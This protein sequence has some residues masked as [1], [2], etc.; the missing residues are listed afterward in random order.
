M[1]SP[2]FSTDWHFDFSKTKK[3][4]FS[5]EPGV[6][7]GFSWV[8]FIL[9]NRSTG[10]YERVNSYW[11]NAH[12]GIRKVEYDDPIECYMYYPDLDTRVDA[13]LQELNE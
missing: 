4:K 12:L 13:R 8:V 6:G 10:K 1:E 9:R 2:Q 5:D 3:F 7:Q 11:V